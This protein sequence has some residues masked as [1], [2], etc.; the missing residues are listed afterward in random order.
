MNYEFLTEEGLSLPPKSEEPLSENGVDHIAQL[1]TEKAE[2][3][4][5][6]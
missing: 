3:M 6:L 2:L 4:A 1:K 5:E